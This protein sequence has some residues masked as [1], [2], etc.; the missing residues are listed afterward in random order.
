[1]F[2]RLSGKIL[3]T[4]FEA[5]L[6]GFSSAQST[7]K[8]LEDVFAE[9]LHQC[10]E[11]HSSPF[12]ELTVEGEPEVNDADLNRCELKRE[13]AKVPESGKPNYDRT[14]DLIAQSTP[15]FEGQGSLELHVMTSRRRIRFEP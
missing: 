14:V 13:M 7:G 12:C 4:L 2:G 6:Q 9:L 1:M 10:R 8:Q 5:K 11:P 3:A 15:F